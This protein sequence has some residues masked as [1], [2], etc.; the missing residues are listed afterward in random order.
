MSIDDDPNKTTGWQCRC[1]RLTNPNRKLTSFRGPG[2]TN[3]VGGSSGGTSNAGNPTENVVDPVGGETFVVEY[4][5][6]C[7]DEAV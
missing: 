2:F 6:R 1:F 7:K 4:K 5:C 3:W